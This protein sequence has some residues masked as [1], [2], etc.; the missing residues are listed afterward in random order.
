MDMD[1]N[2]PLRGTDPLSQLVRQDLD[3]LSIDELKERIEQL[4]SEIA[5]CESKINAASS[6]RNAADALFRKG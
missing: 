1:E 3:P 5:R 4:K 2:L 6:H